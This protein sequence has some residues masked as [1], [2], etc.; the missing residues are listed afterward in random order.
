MENQII[1]RIRKLCGVDASS[2]TKGPKGIANELSLKGGGGEG[3]TGEKFIKFMQKD[4]MMV[5]KL[6]ASCQMEL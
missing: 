3:P 2:G 6:R 4:M 5:K 1:T